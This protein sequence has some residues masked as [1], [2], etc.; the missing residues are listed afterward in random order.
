MKTF[1][2]ILLETIPKDCWWEEMENLTNT[3]VHYVDTAAKAYAEQFID[4]AVEEAKITNPYQDARWL[5]LKK[6]EDIESYI[7]SHPPKINKQSI[8]KLKEQLK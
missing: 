5:G 6:F 1:K 3:P 4:A 8:L 2:E 7:H